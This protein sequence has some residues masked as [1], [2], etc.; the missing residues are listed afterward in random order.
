MSK[1]FLALFRSTTLYSVFRGLILEAW[2]TSADGSVKAL[3]Y[4]SKL[5]SLFRLPVC[6][7]LFTT[8]FCRTVKV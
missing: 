5:V 2:S 6:K 4:T 3:K 8:G 1:Y 7:L